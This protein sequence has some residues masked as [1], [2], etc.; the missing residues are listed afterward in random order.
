MEAQPAEAG[1]NHAAMELPKK[2]PVVPI[3][4]AI[5]GMENGEAR[6]AYGD[7]F[8]YAAGVEVGYS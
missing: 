2:M 8:K 3:A 4:C 5:L 1:A 6:L 7:V